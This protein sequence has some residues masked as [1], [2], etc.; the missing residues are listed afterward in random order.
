MSFIRFTR[1]ITPSRS[2]QQLVNIVAPVWSRSCAMC[3]RPRTAAS[4]KPSSSSSSS[5]TPSFITSQPPSRSFLSP[6]GNKSA[7]ITSQPSPDGEGSI[8]CVLVS[9]AKRIWNEFDAIVDVRE[10][11]EVDEGMIAGA[12]HIPLGNILADPNIASLKDKKQVL[13]YCRAGIRSAK[14]CAAMQKQ[15]I[16]VVNLGGGYLAWQGDQ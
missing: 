16:K 3:A 12:I 9:D 8:P 10:K 4:T 6:P 13:V 7:L 2:T 14:A 15:G 1:H 11:N 5:S